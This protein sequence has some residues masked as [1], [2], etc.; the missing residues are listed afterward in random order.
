MQEVPDPRLA[1]LGRILSEARI[2]RGLTL[3]DVERE[4]RIARRYLEALEHDEFDA[5]PAPVYCRAFLRTYAQ[6]LGIDS[7]EILRLQPDQGRQAADLAPLPQVTKAPPPAL[8]R[9]WVIAGGVVLV[10]LLAGFLLYKIGSGGNGTASPTAQAVVAQ[11]TQAKN[12]GAEPLDLTPTGEANAVLGAT[13][14]PAVQSITLADF[15][16]GAGM[17]ALATVIGQGLKFVV[18]SVHDDNVPAGMVI[19]QSPAPNS[20]VQTGDSITLLVS[21][22]P[23]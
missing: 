1:V 4:T 18:V 20:T 17:Q 22:G 3:D 9:N 5:L 14:A 6:F 16:G 8:S 23:R 19:N 21:E 2:S 10:F 12:E 13:A 7:K 11:A 15:R